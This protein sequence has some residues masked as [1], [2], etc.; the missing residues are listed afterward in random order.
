M[1]TPIGRRETTGDLLERLAVEG[2]QLLLAT[3]DGLEEGRVQ[4]VPQP[5]DGVS[6]A[7]KLTVDTLKPVRPSVR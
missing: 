6:Y 7:P 3:V 4:A 1:T 5:E 2:A